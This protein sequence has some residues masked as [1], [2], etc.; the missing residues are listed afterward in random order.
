MTMSYVISSFHIG[1]CQNG[2][3]EFDLKILLYVYLESTNTSKLAV[4][5]YNTC[6]TQGHTGTSGHVCHGVYCNF[7]FKRK[8]NWY[9]LN[10]WDTLRTREGP[11]SPYTIPN[12][13]H[14]SNTPSPVL[15]SSPH[16][17][18]RA[19]N[20]AASDMWNFWPAFHLSTKVQTRPTPISPLSP[21]PLLLFLPATG[22]AAC[23]LVAAGVDFLLTREHGI[24]GQRH[25]SGWQWRVVF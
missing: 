23:C 21:S 20:A 1:I 12:N 14:H 16:S 10:G 3:A 18:D 13:K 25:G 17:C 11:V 5:P 15:P 8:K 2:N 4:S 7:W 9:G 6:A 19:T 22:A 24:W